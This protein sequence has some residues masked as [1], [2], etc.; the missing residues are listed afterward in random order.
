M[1]EHIIASS[2]ALRARDAREAVRAEYAEDDARDARRAS[3]IVPMVLV[4]G[5]ACLAADVLACF[6]VAR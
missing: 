4:V 1:S 5:A 3:W 6:G 2:Y